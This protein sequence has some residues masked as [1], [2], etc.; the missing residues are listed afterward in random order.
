MTRCG[1]R[2][3]A[4][5]CFGF[6]GHSRCLNRNGH[7]LLELHQ[8]NVAKGRIAAAAVVVDHVLRQLAERFVI[9]RCSRSMLILS[10]AQEPW[11]GKRCSPWIVCY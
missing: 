4:L 6:R 10:S 2:V 11:V 7:L 1:V 3:C 9:Y 5:R 8:G